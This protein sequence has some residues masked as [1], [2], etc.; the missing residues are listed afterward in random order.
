LF[1]ATRHL[2]FWEISLG[3]LSGQPWTNRLSQPAGDRKLLEDIKARIQ[4]AQVRAGLAVNRE[5]V[6]LYWSIGQEI[7]T[8]QDRE[9]W[10]AKVIDSLARD[11]HLSFPDERVVTP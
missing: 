10:G 7:L 11:L 6:L 8:R 9:G 2:T 3:L 5:L 4:T 1:T